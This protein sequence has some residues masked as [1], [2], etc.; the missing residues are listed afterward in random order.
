LK[1]QS[2]TNDEAVQKAK[3]ELAELLNRH[4]KHRKHI[5]AL[6]DAC[7][8][9]VLNDSYVGAIQRRELEHR[10]SRP[11]LCGYGDLCGRGAANDGHPGRARRLLSRP[12][13][14]SFG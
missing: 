5:A 12:V 3:G 9:S 4:T 11:K 6:F 10:V 1:Q 2:R 7:V 14:G 13:I 8:K